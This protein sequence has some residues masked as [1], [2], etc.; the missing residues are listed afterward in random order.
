MF[1]LADKNKN[2]FLKYDANGFDVA[3]LSPHMIT[4]VQNAAN[5]LMS[6]TNDY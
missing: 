5:S 6:V 1:A 4:L 2:V 3:K